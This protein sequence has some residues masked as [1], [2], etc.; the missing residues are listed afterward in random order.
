MDKAG[1]K[2]SP[3]IIKHAQTIEMIEKSH[4]RL[5]Q[6]LKINVSADRPQWDRFVNRAVMAHNTT[7]HQSLKCGTTKLGIT[8]ERH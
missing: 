7:Y 1:I 8:E 4:Q 6:I 5:K 3:A 2:I